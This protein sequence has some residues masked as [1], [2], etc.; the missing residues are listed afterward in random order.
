MDE[1]SIYIVD[2]HEVVI[3]GLKFIMSKYKDIKIIGASTDGNDALK[4]INELLPDIVIL[5]IYLRDM[6]GM[7]IAKNLNEN[8]KKPRIIFHTSYID[9]Q[10]I[11]EGFE[12]GAWSYIPKE[13][14]AEE[15]INAIRAVHKGERYIK[16]IVSDIF[17]DGYFQ[18]KKSETITEQINK[19]LSRREIEILKLIA[20]GISQPDIAKKLF[21]SIKTVNAHKYNIMKKLKIDNTA[22]LIKYALNNNL[23]AV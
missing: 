15:L 1:I 5:D 4:K 18:V 9:A 3:N 23:T 16:G 17:L 12:A 21:I 22:D 8:L 19:T 7:E 13:F 2:D 20:D 10:N 11:I 14:D 6:S